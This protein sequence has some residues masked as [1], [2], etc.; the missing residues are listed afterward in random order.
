M[1]IVP[2][3]SLHDELRILVENGLTPYEAIK[4][5]TV[6]AS[7]VAAAMTGTND[8]GSIEVG[9]RADLILVNQNPL[10]DIEHVKELHGVM[11]GGNWYEGAYL[12]DIVDPALIPG[13][14]FVGMITNVHEPDNTFRTYVDL[15]MLDR[16]NGK[17]P[18]DIE[19]VTVTG[20]QGDLPIG[21]EDFTWLPQF[22]E[23]WGNIPGSPAVGEYTIT[24]AG[25]DMRGKTTEFQFV[26][27]TLPVVDS[28]YFSPADG[29]TIVSRTPT[30]SWKAIELPDIP[31]YYRLIIRKARSGKRVY[32]S[33]R[34]QN[35][36][37]HTVPEGTLK[38]GES[39]RWRVEATDSRYGQGA[40]N[41]SNSKWQTITMAKKLE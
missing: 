13:I 37:S 6:N 3:V 16:F 14:P 1:G 26:N 4:T 31:I 35:M 20:P 9:K 5:G 40:K 28:E 11:A 25:K 12:K 7:H 32:G 24:I 19:T 41:R 17:L 22:R 38:P 15:I 27:R 21:R 30:F 8:F 2:G 34:F 39:Y 10:Q 36:R 33:G 23:F 18:D 29:E